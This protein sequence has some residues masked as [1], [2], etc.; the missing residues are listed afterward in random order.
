MI[1]KVVQGIFEGAGKD[2]AGKM[3]GNEFALGVGGRFVTFFY[4]L[5]DPVHQ[6]IW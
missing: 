5:N 2:L 3:N 6:F 1:N 4:R